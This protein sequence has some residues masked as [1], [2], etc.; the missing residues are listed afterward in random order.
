[1]IVNFEQVNVSR[2]SIK[3]LDWQELVSKFYLN[4]TQIFAD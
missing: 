3:N 1:M 2:I 4:S